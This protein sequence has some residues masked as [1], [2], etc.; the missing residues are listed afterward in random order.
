MFSSR[1]GQKLEF[2]LEVAV[3]RMLNWNDSFGIAVKRNLAQS[4]K[5]FVMNN[6][7]IICVISLN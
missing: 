7:I 6:C 4:F 5:S 1:I 3:H 2:E